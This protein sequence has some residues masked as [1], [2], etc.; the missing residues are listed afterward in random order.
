ML[1]DLS[2]DE[3]EFL[4]LISKEKEKEKDYIMDRLFEDFDNAVFIP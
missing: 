4:D 3:L 1:R 2:K